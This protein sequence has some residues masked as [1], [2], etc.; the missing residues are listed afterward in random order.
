[1]RDDNKVT[2]GRFW[3]GPTPPPQLSV[4]EDFA[5]SLGWELGDRMAFDIAGRRF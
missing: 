4:E 1:L 3:A 2:A 5:R